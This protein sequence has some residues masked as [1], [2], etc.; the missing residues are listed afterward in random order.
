MPTRGEHYLRAEELAAEAVAWP[1]GTTERHDLAG[2]AGIHALLA[3]A[4]ADAQASAYA[5]RAGNRE[6]PA[7]ACPDC[8]TVLHDTEAA[9]SHKRRHEEGAEQ[10][11]G[12]Q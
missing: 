9:G 7:W 11:A 10:E 6:A 4:S 8:G 2:L 5:I 1:L 12:E 3:G